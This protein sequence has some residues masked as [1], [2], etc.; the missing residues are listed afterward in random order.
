LINIKAQLEKKIDLSCSMNL[1]LL[2]SEP[3]HKCRNIK[4][5]VQTNSQ[6]KLC[7]RFG[8]RYRK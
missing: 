6:V 7:K 5:L 1:T 2:S 3:S 4:H 8:H